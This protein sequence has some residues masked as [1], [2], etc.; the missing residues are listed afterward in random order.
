MGSHFCVLL[1]PP[2]IPGPTWL[3]CACVRACV[4]TRV[5]ACVRA[6]VCTCACAQVY[7]SAALGEEM[8]RLPGLAQEVSCAQA[9]G[10]KGL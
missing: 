8:A 1:D 4:C 6:C 5:C 10:G 2:H 3:R 7:S 9:P